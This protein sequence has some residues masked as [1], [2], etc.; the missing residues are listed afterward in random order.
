MR[1]KPGQVEAEMRSSVQ[2]RDASAAWS[3]RIHNHSLTDLQ[4]SNAGADIDHFSAG[5]MAKD[6][7]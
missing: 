7:T 3:V 6:N 4:G 2:A 5:F 1:P